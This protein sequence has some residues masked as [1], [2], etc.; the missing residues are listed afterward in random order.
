MRWWMPVLW[1]A[2]C[3][4]VDAPGGSTD[5]GTADA[6]RARIGLEMGV[7]AAGGLDGAVPASVDGGRDAE[8]PA[9]A[10]TLDA[11]PPRPEAGPVDAGRPP[12]DA[13]SPD[14]APPDAAPPDARA[15]C[16][17]ETCNG[18]DDDCDGRIDEEPVC[19]ELIERRCTVTLGWADNRAGPLGVSPSWSTC[20]PGVSQ[21][22]GD[23]RCTATR[24]DGAFVHLDLDGDVDD[25][26]LLAVSLRCEDADFADAARWIETHCAVFLGHADNNRG[27]VEASAAWG[28]CPALSS[29]AEVPRCTS[30]GFDGAFRAMQL[31]G[32]VDDNDDLGLAW[33]CRDAEQPARA[34]AA[35]ASAEVQLA[36][37][38]GNQGPGDGAPD[39]GFPCPGSRR[40]QVGRIS[41]P[42]ACTSTAGDGL[43]HHLDLGQDIDDN[44]DLGIALKGR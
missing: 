13:R 33:I 31:A 22:A 4:S 25:N 29:S 36:W 37:S 39:W 34:A 1:L 30:S 42:Q 32:D 16:R 5:A 9:D 20:P 43:F 38:A 40:L 15:S 10:A 35:Q 44:D 23:V 17:D 8:R 3:A 7:D 12:A 6:L 28:G 41:F 2:G 21:M 19:G 11:E 24:R 27:P 14:A 26:D 18:A